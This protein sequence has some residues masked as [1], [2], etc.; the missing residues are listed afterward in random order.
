MPKDSGTRNGGWE[1][2]TA[3]LGRRKDGVQAGFGQPSPDPDPYRVRRRAGCRSS[4]RHCARAGLLVRRRQWKGA[5]GAGTCDADG[6]VLPDHSP[7]GAGSG[8]SGAPEAPELRVDLPP[9]SALV[10]RHR[11]E[12]GTERVGRRGGKQEREPRGLRSRKH[13][14]RRRRT[15]R[16][17]RTVAEQ[18][19]RK[20]AHNVR[21]R[22]DVRAVLPRSPR[23]E[24][25]ANE[26]HGRLLIAGCWGTPRYLRT[27]G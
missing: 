16:G 3:M 5:N 21:G 11:A 1:P 10:I 25:Q 20:R 4:R 24:L 8:G 12:E 23:R 22:E 15:W 26:V 9:R 13:E 14:L 7:A 18:C 6:K 2:C 19:T 17:A 27:I